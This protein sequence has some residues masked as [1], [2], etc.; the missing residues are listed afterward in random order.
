MIKLLAFALIFCNFQA[1]G[2]MA[3]RAKAFSS[4]PSSMQLR[5]ASSYEKPFSAHP[6]A[7]KT[8]ILELQRASGYTNQMKADNEQLS[9]ILDELRKMTPQDRRSHNLNIDPYQFNLTKLSVRI[10]ATQSLLN[11]LREIVNNL[12]GK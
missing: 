6:M 4:F 8:S 3:V 7:H 12:K 10:E 2:M 9:K 5:H 1:F 11:M